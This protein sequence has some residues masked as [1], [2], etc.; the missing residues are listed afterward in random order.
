[1]DKENRECSPLALTGG[2]GGAEIKAVAWGLATFSR[3]ENLIIEI[4]PGTLQPRN[5]SYL[6]NLPIYFTAICKCSVM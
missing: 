2:G 4:Y 3:A 6:P 1:M 5:F